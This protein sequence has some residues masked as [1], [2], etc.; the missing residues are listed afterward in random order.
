MPYEDDYDYDYYDNICTTGRNYGDCYCADCREARAKAEQEEMRKLVEQYRPD[1]K[2]GNL[3]LFN[4]FYQKPSEGHKRMDNRVAITIEG[5]VE[6]RGLMDGRNLNLIQNL[7]D[8]FAYLDTLKDSGL[9]N[10]GEGASHLRHNF[11]ELSKQ[12]AK[13]VCVLWVQSF[14]IE[15]Q[16]WKRKAEQKRIEEHKRK[17]GR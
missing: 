9:I 1:N 12:E 6:T 3:T 2:V 15:E 16:E 14:E 13:E 8:Y 10:M 5:I 17:N 11:S 7:G 4:F